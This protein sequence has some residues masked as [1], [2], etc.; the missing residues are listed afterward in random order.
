M[1]LKKLLKRLDWLNRL[2][3]LKLSALGKRRKRD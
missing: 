3:K 2:P 1:K